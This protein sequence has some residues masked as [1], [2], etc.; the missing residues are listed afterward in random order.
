MGDFHDN[1]TILLTY[2]KLL[3]FIWWR[4]LSMPTTQVKDDNHDIGVLA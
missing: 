4:K 3:P 2:N 1:Q